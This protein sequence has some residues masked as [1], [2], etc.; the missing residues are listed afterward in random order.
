MK[1]S[2]YTLDLSLMFSRFRNRHK[3]NFL[4]LCNCRASVITYTVEENHPLNK[5]EHLAPIQ[6]CM[7]AWTWEFVGIDELPG[8]PWAGGGSTESICFS[9]SDNSVTNRSIQ[10]M[11]PVAYYRSELCYILLGGT[12]LTQSPMSGF[13]CRKVESFSVPFPNTCLLSSTFPPLDVV[14]KYCLPSVL[15]RVLWRNRI[16]GLCV[17]KY[18]KEDKKMWLFE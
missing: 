2:S 8:M 6:I 4:L 5:S 17:D 15:N 10:Q 7:D 1:W 12:E 13:V 16:N 11:V 3:D 18:D 9:L 14:P